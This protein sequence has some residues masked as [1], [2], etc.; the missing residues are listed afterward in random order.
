MS[1]SQR[2]DAVIDAALETKIVGC[3]VLVH[4][5]G[6]RVYG[7]A[8]GFADREAGVKTQ[9]NTIF[10]LASV[11][12]PIVA[13]AALRMIELGL[14]SLD[15]PVTKYLPFFTMKA[16]DGS[17]PTI[18]IRHL[19]THTSGIAYDK[20]PD[21][22]TRGGDPKPLFPLEEN[23]RRLARGELAFKPGEN[24]AYGMS[25]DVLGGVLGAIH[26]DVSDVE[27]VTRKYVLDPLGMNDTRFGVTDPSRLAVPYG[28][29][30]PPFRMADPQLM[31]DSD[32]GSRLMSPNRIFQR[33]AAQCAGSGMAGTAGDFMKLLDAILVND[34][35]KPDTRK[36]AFSNQIGSY[37]TGRRAGEQFGFLS[38]VITDARA[39]GWP[40]DG[41]LR[42]GGIW[43][44]TWM[45]DPATGT[46]LI[47]YT[48]TMWE[49]DTG[50][51]DQLKEAVFA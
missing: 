29:G 35:L 47:G 45:L 17:V 12:K 27:S 37:L 16:A 14:L 4:D 22:V 1:L 51:R 50:F 10:R 38:A 34:F 42:W 3:V 13:S 39:A 23:L 30:D 48:N 15:D 18:T 49:G 8:A 5:A 25:I 41:M 2:V 24:W 32:G 26:G 19:L 43:G 11:T 33:E 7:R 6:K 36:A 46:A 31:I 9:E 44:N 21:N 20:I 40:R 28:D